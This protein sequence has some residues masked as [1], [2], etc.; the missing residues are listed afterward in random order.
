MITKNIKIEIEGDK[1]ILARI[2]PFDEVPLNLEAR[3]IA[4]YSEEEYFLIKRVSVDDKNTNIK[5]IINSVVN[6]INNNFLILYKE[7]KV[8]YIIEMYMDLTFIV[9]DLN[10]SIA[11]IYNKYNE[12]IKNFQYGKKVK[13]IALY[14]WVWKSPNSF[15]Y[16]K[17]IQWTSPNFSD[18]EQ[19]KKGIND[20]MLRIMI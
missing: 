7:I 17:L 13:S 11:N 8:P 6:E 12:I 1:G 15:Y 3:S 4:F 20:L 14:M 10:K 19:L 2:S 9:I 5:G 18:V 16:E